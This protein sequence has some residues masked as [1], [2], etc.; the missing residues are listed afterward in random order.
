ARPGIEDVQLPFAGVEAYGSVLDTERVWTCAKR[1]YGETTAE[2]ALTLIL[3]GFRAL[4]TF[5]P[6]TTWLPNRGRNLLEAPVTIIGAGGIGEALIDLLEPFRCP[7]TVVRRSERPVK[8]AARTRPIDRLDEALTD[9]RVVV[10][11]L[12]LTPSTEGLVDA[13]VLDAMSEEAWLVNVARGRHVVTD[14]LVDALE[15]GSIAGAALDVT[16]PEP[17]PDG[18]RLWSL[19]NCLVTPHVAN[20]HAMLRPRLAALV[21]DNVRRR[22]AGEP[23]RGVVDPELGY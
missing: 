2:H 4:G 5:L 17:L 10:L 21:T 6:A 11:A 19:E 12:A 23:L 20:T 14:D 7:V 1:V 13:A 22:A 3:A 15:R 16:D 9:A 18:H 8:G